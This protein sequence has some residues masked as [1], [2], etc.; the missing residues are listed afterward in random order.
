[1]KREI[2]GIISALVLV[3][4]VLVI[5]TQM[6]I[7][8]LAA[9]SH[10]YEYYNTGDD[11]SQSVYGSN[12]YAQTFTSSIAHTI[13][14]VKLKL[15]RTGSPGTV[16]VSIRATDGSGHPIL[17]DL[18]SGTTD[19]NTLP[20]ATSQTRLPTGDHSYSGTWD[21]T[22]NMY[23][24]VDDDPWS[25]NDTTYLLHGT[26]TAGYA[27]FTFSAFTVPAGSVITNLQVTY[28]CRDDT[29]GTNRLNAALRV[30][31]TDYLTTDGGA[32]PDPTTYTDR[33]YSYTTN[34]ATG[35]A[36]TVDDING[37]GSY[38]LQAFGIRSSDCSPAIRITAVEAVVNYYT[39]E[40]REIT[41][42]SSYDLSASTMY[43]IVVRAPSGTSTS[44][45][46]NWRRDASSPTYAGGC[47][48]AS[49]SSGSDGSWTSNTNRDMM[50]EEWGDA[51]P[52]ADSQSGLTVNSCSTLTVTLNGSDPDN[53]PLTYIISTLPL[54]GDLYDGTG[55]GGIKITSVPYTVT[56]IT[57]NVTYQPTISYNDTDS[58][59]FK[60]ND[61]ALDSTEA[62]ISITIIGCDDGDP[63]HHR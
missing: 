43:A 34:P 24:Y 3:G 42:T 31:N 58:F 55:T 62:T 6:A 23:S 9:P 41:F 57:H 60:V 38:P 21:K 29:S 32:N 48:E 44:N 40:W 59:G 14:S 27:L 11:S 51:A 63:L 16:T 17:P 61:G 33:T 26:T 50:F 18:C 5:A 4:L 30:N 20:T 54:H 8:I 2:V 13:T 46:I 56:D 22:T 15:Y 25:D 28:R 39:P 52:L 36:W 35:S 19:G 49:G 37:A 47:R 53:D 10:L 1:M 7:P 12:W 45:C